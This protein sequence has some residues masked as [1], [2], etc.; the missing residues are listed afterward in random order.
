MEASPVY[1]KPVYPEWHMSKGGKKMHD[2]LLVLIN[3]LQ[4]FTQPQQ[5]KKRKQKCIF[6]FRICNSFCDT[7][8]A[9]MWEPGLLLLGRYF[10][11]LLY[12]FALKGWI[13]ENKSN[14]GKEI[15]SQCVGMVATQC[16]LL[17]KNALPVGPLFLFSDVPFV[18]IIHFLDE[19]RNREVGEVPGKK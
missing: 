17:N 13:K 9:F 14:T 5:M 15:V 1:K 10:S 18:R 16:F 7:R 4:L 11:K 2:L 3:Q 8:K 12:V 6:S 19:Q